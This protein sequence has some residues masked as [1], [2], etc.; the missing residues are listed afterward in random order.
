MFSKHQQRLSIKNKYEDED[1]DE[2]EDYDAPAIKS[3]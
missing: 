2:D 3:Y 1:E